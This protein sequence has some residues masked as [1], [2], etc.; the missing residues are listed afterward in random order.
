[1]MTVVSSRS[2]IL[3]VVA[4]LASL[5]FAASAQ[6]ENVLTLHCGFS[7]SRQADPI[8]SPGVFPSAHMHDFFGSDATNES[9][10]ADTLLGTSTSCKTM[11]DTAGYWFPQPTWNGAATVSTN[12]GE[13]WQRPAGVPVVAPPHGMT[14]VAGDSHAASP[15]DNPHLSWSCGNGV[16]SATP[17]NCT[18]V[19]GGSATLTADLFFPDCWDGTTAFDTPAG[20]AP[21]HFAYPVGAACPAG[22][23]TRISKLFV[24]VHFRDVAG[25]T[26][27]NPYNADGTLALGFSSGAFY[28]FHGDFLNG[29]NQSALQALIDGCV[30]HVGTCP[31]H[32]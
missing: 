25:K 21:S 20:I 9:S 13:Y 18:G 26:I 23:A 1:M 32:A 16:E 31:P 24:H 10:T 15:A 6:A 28:T 3:L 14:F 27:V 12:L 22:F 2:S 8:V 4:F 5:V 11:G 29:W 17:P 30:N 19:T 7:H